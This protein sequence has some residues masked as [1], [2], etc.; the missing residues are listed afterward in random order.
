MLR[1]LITN[2]DSKTLAYIVVVAKYKFEGLRVLGGYLLTRLGLVQAR[3]VQQRNLFYPAA[4]FS[5]Y[6]SSANYLF[7]SIRIGMRNE[8]CSFKLFFMHPV[9]PISCVQSEHCRELTPHLSDR[10]IPTTS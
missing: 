10:H 1:S 2:I 4:T 6:P 3:S 9:W 7:I 5:P 8:V